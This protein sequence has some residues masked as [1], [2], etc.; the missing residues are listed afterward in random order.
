MAYTQLH[1]Q[2]LKTHLF[3]SC[4]ELQTPFRQFK[5]VPAL[6]RLLKQ[7][8][9][10][11][12]RSNKPLKAVFDIF[13]RLSATGSRVLLPFTVFLPSGDRCRLY[14]AMLGYV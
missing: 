9:Q 2:F 14:N 12:D 1:K 6:Q 5:F 4:I 11:Y 3:M 13:F 10:L 8:E 7:H